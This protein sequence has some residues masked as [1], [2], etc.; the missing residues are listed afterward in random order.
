MRV[1]R[2]ACRVLRAPAARVVG[3]ARRVAGLG[4]PS[5][6]GGGAVDLVGAGSP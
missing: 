6:P 4:G 1:P 3:P 5:G 2:A